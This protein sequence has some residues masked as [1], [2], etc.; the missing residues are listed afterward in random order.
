[1]GK[2]LLKYIEHW[3]NGEPVPVVILLDLNMPKGKRT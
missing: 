2:R 1:M 3:E